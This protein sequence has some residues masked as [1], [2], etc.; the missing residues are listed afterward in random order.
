[1]SLRP[2]DPPEW[3]L[4]WNRVTGEVGSQYGREVDRP[5][6]MIPAAWRHDGSHCIVGGPPRAPV[7]GFEAD[8]IEAVALNTEDDLAYAEYLLST[9]RVPWIPVRS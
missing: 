7:V 6:A 3:T 1:M 9:G 8:P 5:R 2:A 4:R